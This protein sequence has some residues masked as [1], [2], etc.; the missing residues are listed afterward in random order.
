MMAPKG[1]EDA[2]QRHPRPQNVPT[3]AALLQK[4]VQKSVSALSIPSPLSTSITRRSPWKALRVLGDLVQGK[5][6]WTMCLASDKLVMVKKTTPEAGRREFDCTSSVSIH[7][8]VATLRQ[9]FEM[10]EFW[11]MQYDYSRF[12][13]EEVLNVHLR[14]DESHIQIIASSVMITE[15]PPTKAN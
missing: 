6:V 7:P 14:L 15:T 2:F 10:E 9:C 8:N 12:T 5:N 11:Y 1:I 13:L 3:K 4:S